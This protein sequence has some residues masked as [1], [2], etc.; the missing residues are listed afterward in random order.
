MM[1]CLS[2]HFLESVRNSQQFLRLGFKT[3]RFSD[4]EIRWRAASPKYLSYLVLF[5]RKGKVEL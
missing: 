3:L 2:N 4:R 1:Y 5:Y